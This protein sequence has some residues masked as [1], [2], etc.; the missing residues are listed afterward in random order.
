MLSPVWAHFDEI[1]E[2][3]DG[4]DRVIAVCKICRSRLSANSANGTGHLSRH[5]KSCQKKSDHASMVQTRFALNPDGSY[6]NWEYKFEV[7][8]VEL[9]RLIARLDLPFYC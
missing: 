4:E 8:R 5:H 7:A 2:N 3:V 1:T 6:R 9:C